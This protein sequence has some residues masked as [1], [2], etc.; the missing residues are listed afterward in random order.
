MTSKKILFVVHRYVPFAGGS[1]YYVRDMAEEMVKRG[2]D[3]TVL[4]EE[5]KGPQNLVDVTN[6]YSVLI[7][8]KWDLIV[9]H[10]SDVVSQNLVH[11]NA[12]AINS[13]SPV[14]YMIIKPSYTPLSLN[15]VKHHKYLSYSTQNDIDYI[16]EQGV[17]EKAR[18]IRH[19]I[20]HVK[21]L[22]LAKNSEFIQKNGKK[23][24]VSAGGF[25]NHKAMIPLA[26]AFMQ[27]N[28]PNTELRL[29]GYGPGMVYDDT[30]NVKWIKEAS[31][32]EVLANICDADGY[33]MNS[34]EEGFGLVL[35]EAMLLKTPWYAR[36]DVGAVNQL[37]AY[38]KG[39]FNEVQ[40]MQII[41]DDL[42]QDLSKQIKSAYDYVLANH[43]IIQTCNDI[44]DIL[45]A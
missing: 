43:T 1:E 9:V 42:S 39:Y 41:K 37:L 5:H 10:G 33:I 7:N 2:H 22:E 15:G 28:I 45:N 6:D 13:I 4:A 12:L 31:H 8:E 16:L 19:G 38:G 40:L 3:V 17:P 44:E 18:R 14:C 36:T 20:N 29:F 24:F 23:V 27:A 21:E 26:D 25:W 30:E 34:Y 32:G 11:L 35:L